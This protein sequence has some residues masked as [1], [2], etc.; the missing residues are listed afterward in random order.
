MLEYN[1]AQCVD[2]LS[3]TCPSDVDDVRRA[4]TELDRLVENHTIKGY[5]LDL[6]SAVG[7]GALAC[8]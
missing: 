8:S 7:P 1:K 6:V 3:L 2:M 5:L 4:F